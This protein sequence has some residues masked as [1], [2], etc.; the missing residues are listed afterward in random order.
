LEKNK[1]YTLPVDGGARRLIVFA[2]QNS[3]IEKKYRILKKIEETEAVVISSKDNKKFKELKKIAESNK[4]SKTV[5][6]S[7]KKIIKEII[8]KKNQDIKSIIIFDEY[9]EK[10][11]DLILEMEEFSQ[12]DKLII[13]KKSLFN[14]I[15]KLKTNSML[16]TLGATEIPQWN[17]KQPIKKANL[18]IPFQ[19]P[20]NCGS[21]IRTAVAFGIE[22][23]IFLKGSANPFSLKTISS[24]SGTIFDAN[25]FR[26]PSIS[27]L[28][29]IIKENNLTILTLD[30]S[31]KELIDFPFPE[32]FYLLPGIEGPGLPA[33]LKK[34]SIS[35]PLNENVES[36][37]AATA[38]S[39]A[40]YEWHRKNYSPSN[41]QR[42]NIL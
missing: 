23:I 3:Y 1:F 9:K 15:D 2:K 20:S 41:S 34:N 16:L 28:E 33:E 13:L 14:E 4:K 29:K 24:S 27:E 5:L 18:I 39:L 25:I 6:V 40:L 30:K 21:I 12:K 19:D 31:G 7:G 22:N 11:T 38:T 17:F 37:N 10:D 36:L 8:K 42:E 35:I 26:G 32:N